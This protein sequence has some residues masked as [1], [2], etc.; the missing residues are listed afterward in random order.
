MP[1]RTKVSWEVAKQRANILE[2]IR[3][4]FRNRNVIEVETPSLCGNTVT[5]VYIDALDSEYHYSSIADQ[6]QKLYLQT[7][8]EY[9]MKKL[10]ASGYGDIYQICKAFR[11]EEMGRYHNPEFTILEWY[12]LE[13]DH[14]KLMTEV[15]SLLM[16]VLNCK[17]PTKISY[18]KIFIEN[19]FIDPLNTNRIEL[20]SVLQKFNKSS[21][22]LIIEEELDI[23]LEVI[24][25]EIIEPLIGIDAPCFIYNFPATQASLARISPNDIRVA[26]RF[27]CYYKGI[28]LVNGFHELADV[29][30]QQSRFE[31][32]N[33]Q[34]KNKGMLEK[35][36]DSNFILA[37]ESGL[38][39]C[40]G[41]ALGIDRLVMLVCGLKSIEEVITFSINNA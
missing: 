39:D 8:P 23:L 11:D 18:Q 37:L 26:E 32:D 10:L 36:I 27:E 2:K 4:F 3:I 34:R 28:E 30:I 20:L 40:A 17:Q 29:K 19:V 24:F 9:S 7:S 15:S 22:W 35:P 38:P 21:D 41:V 13:F 16:E 5:D 33:L 12:R 25:S 31:K 1:F 14:F 6:S